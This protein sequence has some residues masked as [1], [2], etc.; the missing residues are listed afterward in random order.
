[1][2]ANS[3]TDL[4]KINLKYHLTIL[5]LFLVCLSGC[6]SSYIY[7]ENRLENIKSLTGKSGWTGQLFHSKAFILQ[8]FY[9][10]KNNTHNSNKVLTVFLE[11]DGYSWVSSSQASTDP[12]PMKDTVIQMAISSSYSPSVYIARPCQF[13]K[14][15]QLEKCN[16][17]YWTHSR[18]S[19]EA[20]SAINESISHFKKEYQAKEIRLIGYS[21]G[22]TIGALIAAQRDDVKQLITV[23]SNLDHSYWTKLHHL[24]P[25]SGSL[26]PTDYID[27]LEK[28]KQIHLVGADDKN[29]TAETINSLI[30][31]YKI[32]ENTQVIILEGYN[33][34]CCWKENWKQIELKL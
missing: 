12:S 22:G 7:P 31:N 1:L 27:D 11:G 18:F 19:S 14:K 21:G 5:L 20:V 30:S 25:L 29:V 10:K 16:K 9:S 2:K 32:K 34:T 33:H 6:S 3:T 8:T 26:N 13:T 28:I 4:K 17:K 24:D 23:A 15:Y